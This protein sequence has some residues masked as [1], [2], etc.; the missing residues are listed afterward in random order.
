MLEIKDFIDVAWKNAPWVSIAWM[1]GF[2]HYLYKVSK[3]DKF[4][5][6]RLVIN[7]ALAGWVGYLGQDMWLSPAFISISW[8]CTYP[9]LTLIEEKGA[10][11]IADIIL[12]K[13]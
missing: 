13:P 7:I 2:A 4:S 12:K 8:F 6:G 1:W 11:I 9:I 3:G 10:K 5:F